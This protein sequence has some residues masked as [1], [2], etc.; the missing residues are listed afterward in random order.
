VELQVRQ[1]RPPSL[2][3]LVTWGLG[4]AALVDPRTIGIAVA[5]AALLWAS[6]LNSAWLILGGAAIGFVCRGLM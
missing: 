1:V 5:A 6:R 2:E 4:R 3:H